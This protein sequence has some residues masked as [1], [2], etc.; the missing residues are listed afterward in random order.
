MQEYFTKR[1]RRGVLRHCQL[2]NAEFVLAN[3]RARHPGVGKFCS[4]ACAKVGKKPPSTHRPLSERFWE[5]VE[6]SNGCWIWV[7]ATISHGYGCIGTGGRTTQV[8]HRAAW[9]LRTGETLTS[10]DIIGHVC[11]NPPCVRND[12]IGTYEVR[13][14]I[15]PR[16]GHLF[17]GTKLDNNRDAL[18]KGRLRHHP[19][20]GGFMSGLV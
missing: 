7:G 16:V 19:I 5:K 8:A 1:G 4:A 6:I 2:C 10:Q 11:D 17:K 15:L 9:E 3:Y 14:A 12:D 13:G 20:K 18:A